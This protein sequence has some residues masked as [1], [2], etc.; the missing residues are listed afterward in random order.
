MAK[1]ITLFGASSGSGAR[2]G[3][4]VYE[5]A[6]RLGRLLA[7]AG[8]T[9][10]NGGYGGTME[11]SAKGAREAGGSAIGVTNA[12]F[13]PAPANLYIDDERKAPDFLERLRRLFTLGDAYICLPGGV[14]T[15]TE[16]SL[17]WTLLQT[18][19]LPRRPFLCVGAPWRAVLDAYR[20][21]LAVRPKDFAL[22]T[23]VETV[24]EAV[25]EVV[26]RLG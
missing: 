14:G 8:F 24:E 20:A 12:V 25:D 22:I 13:D 23:L 5:Q 2:P 16:F 10:C 1:V 9:L 6:Y 3:T 15:L 17:A 21:H 26:A 4:D 7:E 11:A 18:R 19:A